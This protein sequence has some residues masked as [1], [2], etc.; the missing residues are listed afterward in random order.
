[1]DNF[2]HAQRIDNLSFFKKNEISSG[3]KHEMLRQAGKF[4]GIVIVTVSFLLNIND[5]NDDL[6]QQHFFLAHNNFRT[7]P[8]K[9]GNTT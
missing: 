7:I 4:C 9:K 1:M 5:V 8:R 2:S 6:F 3:E